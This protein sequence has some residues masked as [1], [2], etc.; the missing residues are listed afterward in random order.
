MNDVERVQEFQRAGGRAHFGI[1]NVEVAG[2]SLQL[3]VSQQE[4][5]GTE[6]DA[7]F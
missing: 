1:G 4:L 6:I 2:G 5:D 7:S 3:G